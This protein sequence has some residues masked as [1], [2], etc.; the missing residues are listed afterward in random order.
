MAHS[1]NGYPMH[2]TEDLQRP[3]RFRYDNMHLSDDLKTVE[4][5]GIEIP[6]LEAYTGSTDLDIHSYAE[7]NKVKGDNIA[8]HF[9]MYDE[10]FQPSVWGKMESTTYQLRNAKVLFTPDFS[11]Y[12]DR[13]S[14]FALQAVFRTRFVGAYWQKNGY[15][16]I[17]T[18]SCS[19]ADSMRFCLLGLPPHSVLGTSSVGYN[20]DK[21]TKRLWFQL[22]YEVED[23]LSPTLIYVYGPEVQIPNFHTP[24]KFI[25]DY[26][27]THFRHGE[28]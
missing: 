20:R 14:F 6:C 1:A 15:Q 8:L 7:R 9:F 13:M 3:R 4:Y 24:I 23:K 2:L 21:D 11:M 26:I 28:L 22:M 12:L 10:G 17:P 27:S 25:P 19:N 18:F 16:V 5:Y